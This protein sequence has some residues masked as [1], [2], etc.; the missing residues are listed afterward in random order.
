MRAESLATTEA[1]FFKNPSRPSRGN[2]A[3]LERTLSATKPRRQHHEAGSKQNTCG[4]YKN[5]VRRGRLSNSTLRDIRDALVQPS[6]SACQESPK[7]GGSMPAR[8]VW[9]RG[10]HARSMSSFLRVLSE[11]ST[12]D[13]TTARWYEAFETCVAAS[14]TTFR[15]SRRLGCGSTHGRTASSQL[16]RRPVPAPQIQCLEQRYP[17]LRAST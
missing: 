6:F 9:E 17:V 1:D 10:G 3:A 11:S 12:F 8:R 2:A 14:Q 16:T 7:R 4:T 5:S 13:A 15:K